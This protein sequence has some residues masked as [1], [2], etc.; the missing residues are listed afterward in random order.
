MQYKRTF[1][2][3][4]RVAIT[5]A[6]VP[7][8]VFILVRVILPSILDFLSVVLHPSASTGTVYVHHRV[9]VSVHVHLA[10][11]SLALI[12]TLGCSRSRHIFFVGPV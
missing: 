11:F 2:C 8:F 12:L 9:R 4:D 1:G 6:H 10:G 7:F 5:L 3:L